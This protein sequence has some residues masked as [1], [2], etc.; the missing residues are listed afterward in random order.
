MMIVMDRLT[1]KP[2]WHQKV[3][4]TAITTGWIEEALSVPVVQL[5]EEIVPDG[6]NSISPRQRPS[7]PQGEGGHQLR[8]RLSIILDR[9]CLDYVSN[10][11]KRL[12]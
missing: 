1:D 10:I 2:D 9:H 3:F 4:D 8:K 5:L 6:W 11:V 12:T 7:G